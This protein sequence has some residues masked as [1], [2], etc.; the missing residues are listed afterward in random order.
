MT[1]R[2]AR[3]LGPAGLVAWA[4][5][6]GAG[7]CTQDAPRAS[8]SVAEA[9]TPIQATSQPSS[10]PDEP[11][12]SRPGQTPATRDHVDEDGVV[13]RGEP[14]SDRPAL[15]V[16]EAM[17]KADQLEGETVKVS[18]P[19]SRVCGKKGCWMSLTTEDG[20]SQLRVTF[21]DYGFFVP[22]ASKGMVATV[23]GAL[24]VK[25][26]DPKTAQHLEDEAADPASR[27]TITGPVREV[28][29][30]ADGLQMTARS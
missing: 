22:K 1:D 30:V 3:L 6:L 23:E 14:L 5:L 26:L 17:A 9:K 4:T 7:A 29:L 8:P 20:T 16:A 13:R 19:V 11:T 28:T 12:A 24:H 25:I 18:G 15:A 2:T 10:R 21:K 27:K